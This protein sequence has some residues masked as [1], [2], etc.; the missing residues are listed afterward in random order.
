MISAFAQSKK[1]GYVEYR[2]KIEAGRAADE[3]I[4][5]KPL[6]L[7]VTNRM[8]FRNGVGVYT[9]ITDR[10]L[11]ELKETEQNVIWKKGKWGYKYE[12]K[13]TNCCVLYSNMK[14]RYEVEPTKLSA[15][16]AG[17][18]CQKVLV[19]DRV[20]KKNFLVWYSP[21]L[22]GGISP[23]DYFPVGGMVL[24]LESDRVTYLATKVFLQ[25]FDK[26][27]FRVPEN[28]LQFSEKAFRSGYIP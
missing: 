17:Y 20:N 14:T 7:E 16:I 23:M 2:I 1:S 21:Q 22:K 15:K 24:K 8:Y 27:F 9:D 25:E 13:D 28:K 6:F 26:D 11:S 5:E 10:D 19:Y 3:P 12:S 4:T 18:N